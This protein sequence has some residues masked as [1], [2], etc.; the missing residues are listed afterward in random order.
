MQRG[1]N[2][3]LFIQLMAIIMDPG[4]GIEH[5]P[6]KGDF[7]FHLAHL[8][9]H[10]MTNMSSG[11]ELGQDAILFPEV[12]PV[13]VQCIYIPIIKIKT[14]GVFEPILSLP[15]NDDFVPYIL[16]HFS[17]G[18]FQGTGQQAVAVLDKPTVLFMP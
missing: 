8:S 18:D 4:S 15:G 13:F 9:Y 17:P 5:I 6:M 1:S 10:G 7:R 2:Q 12:R 3:E 16:I 14:A 11:F